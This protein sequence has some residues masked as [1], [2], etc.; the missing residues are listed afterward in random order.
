MS[1]VNSV[2][3]PN[4]QDILGLG[5]YAK[6][7]QYVPSKNK[8]PEIVTK[9]EQTLGKKDF[10]KLVC[11]Q[12]LHQ[13]PLN[14]VKDTEFISQMANFTSLNEMTETRSLVEEIRAE[15]YL[16]KEVTV[17]DTKRNTLPVQGIVQAVSH[18]DGEINVIINNERYPI[19]D[20]R[21]VRLPSPS[22]RT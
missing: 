22:N 6:A 10:F 5:N 8:G 15:G 17:I 21:E 12:F 3:M 11:A 19:K 7:L 2:E 20:I 14:P 18:K 9:A 1:T 13:D 4:S 16:G